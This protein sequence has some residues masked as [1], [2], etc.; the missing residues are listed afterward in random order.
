MTEEYMS[1]YELMMKVRGE[2]DGVEPDRYP[3]E[4]PW[5]EAD[6]GINEVNAAICLALVTVINTIIESND[7]EVP[8]EVNLEDEQIFQDVAREFKASIEDAAESYHSAQLG[9]TMAEP[10]QYYFS[11]EYPG[12][13]L[14]YLE[15]IT[16]V[17]YETWEADLAREEVARKVGQGK[18]GIDSFDVA[19]GVLMLG[20]RE[21]FVPS[22]KK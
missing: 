19:S 14:G 4:E 13:F 22:D 21:V 16:T 1:A 2:R 18:W 8:N 11:N 20:E 3:L 9:Q 10:N 7:D 15:W 6:L 5:D 12:F 17:K